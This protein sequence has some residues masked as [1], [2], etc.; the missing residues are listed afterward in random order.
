MLANGM[1]RKGHTIE[2][3]VPKPLFFKLSGNNKFLG[4]WLGYIDQFLIFPVQ[5]LRRRRSF[6]ENTL[7]VITDHALGPWVP[8]VRKLPHIV[9]CHDFLAQLSAVGKIE[10]YTTGWS[11]RL[12][13]RLIRWGYSQAQYFISASLKTKHDLHY[14]INKE[15]VVSEV[16]YNTQNRPLI[17]FKVEEARF[18]LSNY[19]GVNLKAGYMLHVGGNL[20][21]KNREGVIEIYE[22]WRAN[23]DNR[24]PL[25][26]VGEQPSKCLLE[27]KEISKYKADIHFVTGLPDEEVNKAYCGASLLLFPS[28]AEGFGWPIIEAMECGCPVVTTGE[29]P[30]N[31]VGGSAAFYIPRKPLEKSLQDQWASISAEVISKVLNCSALEREAHLLNGYQN[32]MRFSSKVIIDDF[33]SIYLKVVNKGKLNTTT[34]PIGTP[35]SKFI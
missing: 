17:K 21:Y 25:I 16:V 35:S 11:G 34:L 1:Q 18:Q 7:F 29:A 14:F 13:Q 26:L 4:K 24:L 9:H 20:W 5:F 31:E 30:M 28:Y 8:M 3:L 33:E 22:S 2:I 23:S 27:K 15:V 10:Q 12:Y 19:I 6:P 32:C